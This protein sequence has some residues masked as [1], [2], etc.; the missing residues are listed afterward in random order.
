MAGGW[1]SG[2]AGK[3]ADRGAGRRRNGSGGGVSPYPSW[4]MEG[5]VEVGRHYVGGGDGKEGHFR[6]KGGRNARS[7]KGTV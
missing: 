2:Q 3:G 6:L 1:V 7:H 5:Q 4:V